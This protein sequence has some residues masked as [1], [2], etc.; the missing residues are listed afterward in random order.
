[1]LE[2][3][4][5]SPIAVVEFLES[6]SAEEVQVLLTHKSLESASAE[7]VQVLLTYRVP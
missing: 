6:A 2:C 7:E 3:G 1:M 4:D 5:P